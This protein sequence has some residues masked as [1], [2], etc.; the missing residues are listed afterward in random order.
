MPPKIEGLSNNQ[1]LFKPKPIEPKPR[2]TETV[3]NRFSTETDKNLFLQQNNLNAETLKLNLFA[4]LDQTGIKTFQQTPTTPSVDPQKVEDAVKAIKES[5]SQG[6]FD[7]DVTH[8]DLENIQKTFQGLNAEESNQAFAKLSDDDLK[9][10]IQELNGW[11]GSYSREEK[12]QLFSELTGKLNGENMARFAK[13]LGNDGFD[14]GDFGRAVGQNASADARVDFVKNMAGSVEANKGASEAVAEAI[15]GLQNDPAALD[16]ALNSLSD[17]Q[18][19]KLMENIT[20]TSW[21]YQ[22]ANTINY[23]GELLS[24]M[25]DAVSKSN[26]PEVKARMFNAA[27]LYLK[28]VEDAPNI[29]LANAIIGKNDAA[30]KIRDSLTK[31]LDSDTTGISN[32]LTFNPTY[33]NGEAVTAYLKSMLK[34][35]KTDEVGNLIAKLAKGNNLSEDQMSHFSTYTTDKDGNKIY[36]NAQMLGYFTGALVAANKQVSGDTEK[37]ADLLKKILS[38]A[39]GKIGV[40]GFGGI[41]FDQ[42]LDQITKAVVDDLSK[43]RNAKVGDLLKATF[44]QI[45]GSAAFYKSENF[46]QYEDRADHVLLQNLK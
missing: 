6:V 46:N 20:V 33:R 35:G 26:N 3:Q 8:G 4:K 18:L 11:N 39:A 36:E 34:A 22:G 40:E 1:E 27:A 43:G 17:T 37:Q 13:L 45:A 16:R 12:Q 19:Q 15:S 31:I 30:A 21:Q 29:M 7:W 9:N 32:H 10:W 24:K 28:S 5:L 23:N 42:T 25:L 14:S 2:Q 41:A 38:T 44:P